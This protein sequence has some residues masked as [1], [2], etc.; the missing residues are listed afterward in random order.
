MIAIVEIVI[1]MIVIVVIAGTAIVATAIVD[2]GPLLLRFTNRRYLSG[3]FV[4]AVF[5]V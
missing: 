5:K 1:A 3:V 4:A 2:V